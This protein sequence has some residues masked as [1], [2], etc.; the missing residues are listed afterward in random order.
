MVGV[1]HWDYKS[2]TLSLTKKSLKND[3]QLLTQ[4]RKANSIFFL[5]EL[6]MLYTSAVVVQLLEQNIASVLE[7]GSLQ[8]LLF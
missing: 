3:T 1:C 5:L 7:F 4:V 6:I 2:L 8:N